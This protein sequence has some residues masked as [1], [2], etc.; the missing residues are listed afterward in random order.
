MIAETNSNSKTQE[1]AACTLK[2]SDNGIGFRD[3]EN[4]KIFDLFFQLD[5]GKH[6]GSG[7]GLAICKKIMEMHGGFIKAESAPGKGTVINCYFPT[8]IAR[9]S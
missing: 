6:K 5:A 4:E 3:E 1:N 7:I 2:I 9:P 8:S